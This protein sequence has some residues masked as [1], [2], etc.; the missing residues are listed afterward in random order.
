VTDRGNVKH[1]KID[2]G[3]DCMKIFGSNGEFHDVW[4]N[5]GNTEGYF[6]RPAGIDIDKDNTVYVCDREN[7]RIQI[8]QNKKKWTTWTHEINENEYLFSPFDIAVNDRND[9]VYVTDLMSK[10]VFKFNKNGEHIGYLFE[11]P[12]ELLRPT[13]IAIDKDNFIYVAYASITNCK[14]VKYNEQTHEKITWGKF[15]TNEGEFIYPFEIAIDN[16]NNWLYVT[17]SINNCIQRFNL[18]GD[19]QF[20]WGEKQ[21]NCP[22]GIIVDHEN[23][24]MIADRN[25]QTIK[26]FSPNGKYL[27]QL[28]IS[29]IASGELMNPTSIAMSRYNNTI[30]VTDDYLN[31]IQIYKKNVFTKG[32]T[33]AIIASGKRSNNDELSDIAESVAHQS[34]ECLMNQGID[35]KWIYYL[36][37]NTSTSV[38]YDN[39]SLQDDID[40]QLNFNTIKYAITEWPF[41]KPEADSLI[42]YFVDH[43]TD[44][45]F[46]MNA[47]TENNKLSSDTL[48]QWLD[49]I[50]NNQNIHQVLF[51]YDA[52]YSGSFIGK[53]S[54]QQNAERVVLTSTNKTGQ[55]YF[56]KHGDISFSREFWSKI[57]RNYS[58]GDAYVHAQ[59]RMSKFD[60]TTQSFVRLKDNSIKDLYLGNYKIIENL[61]PQIFWY[62]LHIKELGDNRFQISVDGVEDDTGIKHVMAMIIKPES[63]EEIIY[64]QLVKDENNVYTSIYERVSHQG[65]FDII[66]YAE[67]IDGNKSNFVK[68]SI[69]RPYAVIIAGNT[70]QSDMLNVFSKSAQNAFEALISQDIQYDDIYILS[71]DYAPPQIP[72]KNISTVSKSN[73]KH[74]LTTT[75]FQYAKDVIIY[76]IGR[77]IYNGFLPDEDKDEYLTPE[78]LNQ[79][80]NII[81]S[82]ITG[83][84]IF[85]YESCQSGR[86]ISNLSSNNRILI[87]STSINEPANFAGGGDI[88][89]SSFFWESISDGI[90]ILDAYENSK[91]K[92]QYISDTLA[93]NQSPQIKYPNDLDLQ[94]VFIGYENIPASSQDISITNISTSSNETDM[95]I[96]AT[97]LT[98]NFD[99]IN[100]VWAVFVPLSN[101]TMSIDPADMCE[102]NFESVELTRTSNTDQFKGIFHEFNGYGTYHI[103]V[104][105]INTDGSISEPGMTSIIFPDQYENDNTVDNARLIHFNKDQ[106]RNFFHKGDVDWIK[107]YALKDELITI[108][109]NET[110]LNCKP[111]IKL[112][113]EN[114]DINLYDSL[115]ECDEDAFY[116]LKLSNKIQAEGQQTEYLIRVYVASGDDGKKRIEGKIIDYYTLSAIENIVVK[117]YNY[118][119]VLTNRDGYFMIEISASAPEIKLCARDDKNKKYI[120]ID[121]DIK[122]DNSIIDLKEIKMKP[123]ETDKKLTLTIPSFIIENSELIANVELNPPSFKLPIAVMLTSDKLSRFIFKSTINTTVEDNTIIFQQ[124]QS[125]KE[126]KVKA[127]NNGIFDIYPETALISV[128]AIGCIADSKP[129]TI[130][131]DS[132]CDINHSGTKN[133]KDVILIFQVISGIHHS[134]NQIFNDVGISEEDACIGIEDALYLLKKISQ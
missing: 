8:R 22:T 50:Q 35:K 86:F 104:Y 61:P 36:S 4:K 134:E 69:L 105:A 98:Q 65:A 74:L 9:T 56:H 120:D 34:Y 53:L 18:D 88:S 89:F 70:E 111:D 37:S 78:E 77:G 84:L 127:V 110:G 17:D 80:F 71:S 59:D 15:G 116:Y 113:K 20:K 118:D 6:F 21:L 81:Q 64:I 108:E 99:D 133:L 75:D 132:I 85:I 63:N 3:V 121:L 10:R 114:E 16:T 38:D 73:I 29:G 24:V 72:E 103:I 23:N 112:Y 109:T 102:Y 66:V 79:Y 28:N 125:N 100:R 94:K 96:T 90:N 31:R 91:T 32:I 92:I 93:Q 58:V 42:I 5:F 51:V 14:I 115:F 30:Y 27:Y 11:Q 97:V 129:I 41:Q 43:G 107:F 40:D 122:L 126:F 106:R 83:N 25:N 87:S 76:I 119:Y 46:I 123:K 45:Q 131:N 1:T 54:S 101:Q 44:E 19:F 26:I 52:C 82:Q 95:E 13:G 12:N 60:Q 57:Y 55:A 130:L 67:D 48:S 124:K 47:D 62:D 128:L 33:K 7:H 2:Y 49:S 68:K 117:I 39:N